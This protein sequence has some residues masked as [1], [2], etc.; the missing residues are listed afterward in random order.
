MLNEIIDAYGI[1]IGKIL[2]I[3]GLYKISSIKIDLKDKK[4]YI[5]VI[6]YT[7]IEVLLT[8]NYF[9]NI[10]PFLNFITLS[11]ISWK[12]L[13]KEP[14]QAIFSVVVVYLVM[15][16]SEISLILIMLFFF[17]ITSTISLETFLQISETNSY[18]S[19]ALNIGFA[20]LLYILCS[21]KK[22][23]NL[24]SNI[25]NFL[26]RKRYNKVYTLIAPIFLFIIFSFQIIFFHNKLLVTISIY[27]SLL[28]LT[29]YVLIRNLK[30]SNEYETTKEK[31]TVTSNSLIKYE[32]MVDKYRVSNHENKNQL[33]M[34]RNMVKQHDNS[35]EGYIDELLNVVYVANE[36]IILEL[37]IIPS[38]GIR[39]TIY[40]K[41]ITMDNKKIKHMINIDHDLKSINFFENKSQITLKICNIISIFIDNAIEEVEL[42]DNKVICIDI[43]LN[44]E[45]TVVFEISN[46]FITNFELDR[47]Y[48]KKYTTKSAGHGYGLA[49]A[50]EII[51]EEPRIKNDTIINDDIFTQI[52]FVDISNKKD[53]I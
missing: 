15:L 49:L 31:Y 12:I 40:S 32:E 11:F 36:A 9:Y 39:S 38:G 19:L 44:N 35:V 22:V 20:V 26:Y 42:Q 46:R 41:L 50:S 45:N 51:A 4:F 27:F 34:I 16:I 17:N 28:I 1:V 2:I 30:I 21:I 7:L 10:R 25:D 5:A 48:E 52:L 53:K 13:R 24:Y 47:I 14:L 6:L 23:V 3:A 43:Y 33:Q 8:N 37:S 29:I 18:I